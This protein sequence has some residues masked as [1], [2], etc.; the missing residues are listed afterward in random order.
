MENQSH[1]YFK[2]DSE[3]DYICFQLSSGENEQFEHNTENHYSQHWKNKYKKV[4]SCHFN[5]VTLD[6]RCCTNK[7]KAANCYFSI[8]CLEYNTETDFLFMKCLKEK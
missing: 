8:A 7:V 2:N 6:L 4:F 1:S 3:N 5:N